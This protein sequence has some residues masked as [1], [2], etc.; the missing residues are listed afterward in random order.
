MSDSELLALLIKTGTKDNNCLELSKQLLSKH[1]S[2]LAGFEYL[3]SASI[4]ELMQHSGIGKVKAVQIKAIVELAKRIANFESCINKITT[5]RDVYDFLGEEMS[6]LEK[7]EMR[8]VI[9]DIKNTVK[10][11]VVLA[12]GAINT[13]SVSA[14]EVLVE[15]IK[16]MASGIILVHNHP[17]GDSTPSRQDIIF[18]KKI[19]ELVAPFDIELKDHIVIGKKRYTSIREIEPKIFIGGRL[20]WVFLWRI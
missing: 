18:T 13:V 10:S 4:D 17:S 1:R 11:V 12:K 3:A 8:V 5:P 19:F 15:P 9:L 6:S 2:G 14:K 16:Q 7:E 20:L